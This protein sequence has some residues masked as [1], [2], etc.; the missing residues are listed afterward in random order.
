MFTIIES[1]NHLT[2]FERI[3]N[4]KMSEQKKWRCPFCDGLN[5]WQDI[6]CQICGDGRRDM[7]VTEKKDQIK[8]KSASGSQKKPEPKYYSGSQKEP[9]KKLEA[10]VEKP[11]KK[12]NALKWITVIAIIALVFYANALRIK[13]I[14][15]KKIAEELDILLLES[16]PPGGTTTEVLAWAQEQGYEAVQGEP[17]SFIRNLDYYLNLNDKN[18]IACLPNDIQ[19]D[20]NAE[21]RLSPLQYFIPNDGKDTD[22]LYEQISQI[23]AENNWNKTVD[24]QSLS[25]WK[26][27]I[28]ILLTQKSEECLSLW[29]DEEMNYYILWKTGEAPEKDESKYLTPGAKPGV[30]IAKL[31][32]T[33]ILEG[34][35]ADMISDLDLQTQMEKTVSDG[36]EYTIG[37]NYH[38][39]DVQALKQEVEK[40]TGVLMKSRALYAT[41]SANMGWCFEYY[42]ET[43]HNEL[44]IE[45]TT[46]GVVNLGLRAKG[47]HE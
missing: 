2:I 38:L 16:C 32:E 42:T 17:G 43:E 33:D 12:H 7:T 19:L 15:T 14:Q 5:D 44:F 40:I 10:T 24:G 20:E 46:D 41:T 35:E 13:W 11:V 39:N 22:M 27:L 6:E 25:K 30:G 18:W 23:L 36:Y 21:K 26:C 8:T 28:P 34:T 9:A 3:N 29:Q 45:I 1:G 4:N 37:F 47:S 31:K